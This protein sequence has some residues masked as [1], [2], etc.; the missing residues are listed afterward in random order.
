[1][2]VNE[3]F[4]ADC[5][6]RWYTFINRAWTVTKKFWRVFVSSTCSVVTQVTPCSVTDIQDH[7]ST[8]VRP[9]CYVSS[10]RDVIKQQCVPTPLTVGCNSCSIWPVA[11]GACLSCYTAC[12]QVTCLTSIAV[13]PTAKLWNFRK[14]W[15]NWVGED[16]NWLRLLELLM[17]I[18]GI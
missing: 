12:S 9:N 5:T 6:E 17:G 7:L 13:W 8:S 4:E 16:K 11:E 18:A 14:K 15:R 3:L 2:D 10:F 1:M